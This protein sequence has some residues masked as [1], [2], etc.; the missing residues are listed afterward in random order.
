MDGSGRF[1]LS[2]GRPSIIRAARWAVPLAASASVA[3]TFLSLFVLTRYVLPPRGWQTP[4][5]IDPYALWLVMCSIAGAA[6]GGALLR[7]HFGLPGTSGLLHSFFAFCA[8]LFAGGLI[9]GTLALPG[10]G[11]FTAPA[12]VL[13]LP[14]TQP[15]SSLL[16]LV[17]Y[18]STWLAMHV[19]GRWQRRVLPPM[20]PSTRRLLAWLA[21]AG[22]YFLSVAMSR[23][24][25]A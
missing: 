15:P 2:S 23:F 14:F 25:A 5:P 8:A 12:L 21:V 4:H 1:L 10:L 16:L 20:T 19:A 11:P 17:P 7:G 6:C 13:I 24:A 9:G 3:C 18:V 22:L